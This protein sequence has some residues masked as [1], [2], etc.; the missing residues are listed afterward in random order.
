MARDTKSQIRRLAYFREEVDTLFRSL[1]VQKDPHA[2]AK[3]ELL[4]PADI[5]E[6]KDEI[7]IRV[8]L[9]GISLEEIE[10]SFSGGVLFIKGNKKEKFKEGRVNYLCIERSFGKFQR[11]IEI[12]RAIDS[13]QIQAK[14]KEGILSIRMP[15]IAERRGRRDKIKIEKD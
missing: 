5:I 6:G 7:L 2:L 13:S 3:G 8:E 11:I 12:P 4:P 9:P 10:V 14:L 15:K 1:F